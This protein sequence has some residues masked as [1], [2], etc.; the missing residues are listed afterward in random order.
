MRQA[1]R[2]LPE[3]RELRRKHPVFSSVIREPELA[4]QVTLQPVERLG[5][6]AAILFSDIMTP[7]QAIVPGVDIH[8]GKGP[9]VDQP[10]RTR[11]D[12]DRLR[13]LEPDLDL[14]YVLE[15]IRMLRGGAALPPVP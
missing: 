10:F 11:A 12:L 1:G 4:A 13:P 7:V 2:S 3:Y 14:P 15:T 6:D 5:V 8:P 9:V